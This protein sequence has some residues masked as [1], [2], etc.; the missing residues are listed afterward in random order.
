MSKLKTVSKQSVSNVLRA[1]AAY[2]RVVGYCQGMNFI[3]AFF[4]LFTK[5]EALVFAL[6]AALIDKLS[7]KKLYGGETGLLRGKFYQ[8]DR[9]LH[10]HLPR[11]TEHFRRE[12]L[13]SSFYASEWFL[14]LF[15]F[16]LDDVAVCGEGRPCD[17]LV[18]LWDGVVVFGWKAMYKVAVL[19]L[20]KLEKRILLVNFEEILKLIKGLSSEKFWSDE[21]LVLELKEGMKRLKI[22]NTALETLEFEFNNIFNDN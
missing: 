7:L 8:L 1:Y 17:F 10:Q 21:D 20:E 18:A 16:V 14:T 19:V 6:L 2:N 11:L 5:N 15:T 22:T 9:L 3:V 12:G 4:L 13:S